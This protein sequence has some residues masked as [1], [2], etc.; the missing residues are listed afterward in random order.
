[1]KRTRFSEEKIIG[2]LREAKGQEAVKT[3][4]AKHNISEVAFYA[5]RRKY[6]GMKVS[7]ARKLRSLEDENA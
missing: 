7:E 4:S 2:I 1:M 6:G 5:R 3:V